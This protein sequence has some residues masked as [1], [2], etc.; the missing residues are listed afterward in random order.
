MMDRNAFAHDDHWY[1]DAH[2]HV[3]GLVFEELRE[4]GGLPV[5]SHR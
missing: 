4:R 1:A 2:A 5:R 3:A